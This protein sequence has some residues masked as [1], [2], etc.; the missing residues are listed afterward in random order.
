ML[1]VLTETYCNKINIQITQRDDFI[2]KNITVHPLEGKNFLTI[3]V[4]Y[5][6]QCW[7]MKT[8]KFKD[9]I[10]TTWHVVYFVGF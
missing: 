6:L 8:T 4:L 3:I 5:V 10:T 1:V 7:G 9:F 2:Q